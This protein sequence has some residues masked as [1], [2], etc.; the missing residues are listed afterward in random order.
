MFTH[1]QH[2]ADLS[3]QGK[4]RVNEAMLAALSH[5]EKRENLHLGMESKHLDEALHFLNTH[6][7]GRHDLKP[8]ER[9]VIEQSFKNHFGIKEPPPESHNEQEE[10]V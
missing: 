8:K 10:I 5:V 3:P 7:E 6:Y 2:V 4:E 1:L 9:Q